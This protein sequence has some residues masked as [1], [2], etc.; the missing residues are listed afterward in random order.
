MGYVSGYKILYPHVHV[1]DSTVTKHVSDLGVFAYD[2]IEHLLLGVDDE[3]V[4][5]IT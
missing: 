5:H 2:S 1:Q 3:W 4:I